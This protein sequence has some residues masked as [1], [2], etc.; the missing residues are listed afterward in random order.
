MR[1]IGKLKHRSVSGSIS[2]SY[3]FIE[4]LIANFCFYSADFFVFVTI[5]TNKFPSKNII[6]KFRFRSQQSHIEFLSKRFHPNIQRCRNDVRFG[7]GS[8]NIIN[9]IQSVLSE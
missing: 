2:E 8:V 9:E 5:F 6:H 1:F 3:D 7:I 4:F